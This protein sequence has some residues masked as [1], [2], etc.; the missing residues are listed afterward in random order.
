MSI[1]DFFSSQG[2]ATPSPDS[3]RGDWMDWF[4]NREG[5]AGRFRGSRR[6]RY[7]INYLFNDGGSVHSEPSYRSVQSGP[8]TRQ[9]LQPRVANE[10]REW[11]RMSN[12]PRLDSMNSGLFSARINDPSVNEMRNNYNDIE[13]HA[14]WSFDA[15]QNLR[16]QI[17]NQ[18]ASNRGYTEQAAALSGLDTGFNYRTGLPAS[19]QDGG[20]VQYIPSVEDD[21]LQWELN[22]KYG[23]FDI[24]F[25]KGEGRFNWSMPTPKWMGG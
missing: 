9:K 14:P 22:N 17:L 19:D 18:V 12:Q 16:N 24:G 10:V 4:L 3:E 13:T 7:G 2:T 25:G 23:N 8:R 5:P 1:M 15:R 11:H 20:W 21:M 6:P